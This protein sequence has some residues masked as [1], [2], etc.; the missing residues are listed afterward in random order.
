MSKR[1]GRAILSI[2]LTTAIVAGGCGDDG[3]AGSTPEQEA[4]APEW[5]APDD[6]IAR[7]AAAGLEPALRE[8]L[9]THRHSHLDVFV[10]GEP[11]TVSAGIGIDITD[12]GVQHFP[13]PNYGGI[14]ECSNPC[15]SPLH[16]HDETGILHTEAAIDDLLTLG[17]FFTEWGVTLADGCVG[18]YCEGDTEIAVY[19]DGEQYDGDPARIELE[20][21]LQI[22]IVIGTPPADIPDTADFSQA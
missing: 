22:A 16:T 12:P 6:P 2:I 7:T 14:E 17:Q 20:D 15:I 10:D 8:H 21:R 13:G 18:E 5:P 1:R 4:S 19:V 11:V 3:D 9:Q